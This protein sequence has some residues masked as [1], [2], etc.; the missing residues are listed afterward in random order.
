MALWIDDSYLNC[1]HAHERGWTA[2][3]LIEDGDPTPAK[4]AAEYEIRDL[5]ELR[6]LFPDF[7]TTSGHTVQADN[8]ES[9]VSATSSQL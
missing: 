7:F 3:H 1:Y 8:K 4:R 6:G 5:E 9:I 2:A